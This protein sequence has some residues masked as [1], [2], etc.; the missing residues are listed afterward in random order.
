VLLVW[1]EPPS[2]VFAT[3]LPLPSQ[4]RFEPHA[5]PREAFD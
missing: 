4:I 2:A 1:Q 5:V 3:Q